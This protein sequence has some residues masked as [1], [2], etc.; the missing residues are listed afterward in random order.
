MY[1]SRIKLRNWKNFKGVEAPLGQRV[2]LIGPNASGKSNLLDALRFLRDVANDGLHKA[3]DDTRGG[4]AAIRCLAATRYSDIDIEVDIA[5][6]EGKKWTYRLVLNQDNVKR[7]VVKEEAV[8]RNGESLLGRPNI[9]DRQDPLLLTQTALE[10]IV[11][12]QQFREIAD[13][14][15][16]ISYQHL[17]PQVVRDPRGFSPVQVQDDPYGRDFLLR[18]WRTT[19]KYRDSRLGKIAQALQSA[20]PQFTDL[21][22][23]MDDSGTPHL[24]GSYTHWRPHAAKQNESQF[25]DG[26]LRLLGLLWTVFEGS[27][28]LLLEEPELSLHPEVVRRLPEILRRIN[29]ERKEPRQIIISTHSEDLLRDPGI[30][31]EE[32]LRLEPTAQGAV[33]RAAEE[34]DRKAMRAGLTAADVLMP[35]AAPA[36]IQQLVLQFD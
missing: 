30:A 11:A 20:V 1:I 26:T 25:S 6:G 24:I 2:F 15:R 28:P 9:N 4:V 14:F 32:V 3:V 21:Q 5:N 8:S 10:Q 18:L 27:G 17:I 19:P 13:F 35:K 7:P 29:R 36:G 22:A 12:N 34:A 31:A 33:I 23:T 16:S